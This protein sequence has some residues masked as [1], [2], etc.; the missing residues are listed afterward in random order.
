MTVRCPACDEESTVIYR[1]DNCG[2]D[3]VDVGEE[4]R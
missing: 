2:R 3:L 1:C 4:E